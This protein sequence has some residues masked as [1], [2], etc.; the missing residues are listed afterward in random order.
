MPERT[1]K[2]YADPS[3]PLA[4]EWSPDGAFWEAVD[5][6]DVEPADGCMQAKVDV[7]DGW[8]RARYLLGNPHLYGSESNNIAVPEPMGVGVWAGLIALGLLWRVKRGT[9]CVTD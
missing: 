6:Y 9:R 5:H 3:E 2:Y 7:G 8:I 4:I 1:F